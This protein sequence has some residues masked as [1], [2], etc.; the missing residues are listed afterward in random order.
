MRYRLK[1]TRCLVVIAMVAALG[2]H[3]AD[4][5][6]TNSN[7]LGSFML[8]WLICGEFPNTVD[9]KEK[10]HDPRRSDGLETDYLAAHGGETAITPVA[11]MTVKRPDGTVAE[12]FEFVSVGPTIHFKVAING[13]HKDRPVESVVAYAYTTIMSE[14][15]GDAV[16]CAGSDDGLR[17]WLN[18]KLVHDV[19]TLRWTVRDADK[20]PV[21]LKK[22]INKLLV[23][24][25]QGYGGWNFMMRIFDMDHV[26]LT[27]APDAGSLKMTAQ[28]LTP[29]SGG[30]K[31]AVISDG[32]RRLGAVTLVGGTN[33]VAEGSVTIPFPPRGSEYANVTVLIGD[34]KSNVDLGNIG[35]A[36]AQAFCQ[37]DL[38]AR[39][40]IFSGK[41]LPELDFER[42]LWIKEL[43]G[44]YSI[45][46]VYYDTNHVVVTEADAVGRY[47]AVSEIKCQDGRTYRRFTTLYRCANDYRPWRL[48]FDAQMSI[49]KEFGVPVAAAE[50]YKDEINGLA[51][52][53]IGGSI[54]RSSDAA[55][56]FAGLGELDVDGGPAGYFNNPWQIDARWWLPVKRKIY[57]WDKDY[58]TPFV[59]PRDRVGEDAH[60]VRKGSLREAGMKRGFPRKLHALLK[61][62][63][64][65]T[66]EAFAVC[67]VR[68][69]VIAFHKAY[70]TR[71]GKPMT[72]DTK[73]WMASTTKMMSGSLMIMLAD[74]GLID[75]DDRLDKYLPPLRGLTANKPVTIRHCYTHTTGLDENWVPRGNDMEE[76]YASVLP[77]YQVGAKYS[78]NGDG[79]NLA[80]KVLEGVSGETLPDFFKKHL[81]APLGCENTDVSD[82]AGS[83]KSTPLDMA[84]IGQMLLQK[85]AYGDKQFFS[86]ESFQR[87]LPQRLVNILGPDTDRVYGIGTSFFENEGLGAGTFAHG[88]AS[89]ATTR[90]DPVNDLVIVMT[91]N[92]AGT[93]HRKYHQRF[94]DTI[95][96]GLDD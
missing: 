24:V 70:G 94:I 4:A 71:D 27:V 26:G 32:A 88:A 29:A 56:F 18:G 6:A 21:V 1:L 33:G 53:L 44:D 28:L 10:C 19:Q 49:P 43:I 58:P 14:R 60:V 80:C 38:L 72:V 23:K 7:E 20:V 34:R 83:A 50:A 48:H 30:G 42:P 35:A 57:G 3:P 12:W 75:L 69:G 96:A 55:T 90:I 46:T 73:S 76:R 51:G 92:S 22:G 61:E 64:A 59:C 82:A 36:R 37:Q 66:D 77:Y 85:G 11:G 93:N 52:R 13:K 89:A 9:E 81:L 68:H 63:A 8:N 87:M 16:I 91:R 67:V 65:D 25:D 54:G 41:T 31:K 86:E 15:G 2:V 79:M 74:Q 17:I 78:Y 40:P 84:R 62:W 39:P 5:A 95:V 47:G 45:N